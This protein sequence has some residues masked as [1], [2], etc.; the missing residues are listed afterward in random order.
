[1]NLS[2][3]LWSKPGK[4]FM[5]VSIISTEPQVKKLTEVKDMLMIYLWEILSS[6]VKGNPEDF[7]KLT[8]VTIS[9]FH[10]HL[11]LTLP[12]E[13]VRIL[14][15]TPNGEYPTL[16]DTKVVYTLNTDDP[17]TTVHANTEHFLFLERNHNSAESP[18]AKVMLKAVTLTLAHLGIEARYIDGRLSKDTEVQTALASYHVGFDLLDLSHVIM[19]RTRTLNEFTKIKHLTI[20]KVPFVIKFSRAFMGL[21]CLCSDCYIWVR[22]PTEEQTASF[23]AARYT[24]CAPCAQTREKRAAEGPKMN[25]AAKKR[26]TT[27]FIEAAQKKLK[28]P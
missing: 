27:N 25:A 10:Q 6:K 17:G 2:L 26:A 4:R 13:I 1:M 21:A 18:P 12:H 14:M 22:W 16:N 3:D 9:E 24:H 23:G 28:K 15:E 11:Q 20:E 19:N 8:E 7:S 5:N